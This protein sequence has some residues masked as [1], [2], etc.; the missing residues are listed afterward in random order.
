MAKKTIINSILA[1]DIPY[2]FAAVYFTVG[3]VPLKKDGQP[4]IDANG[5][6]L[7]PPVKE[8]KHCRDRFGTGA[9]VD[10][11]CYDIHFEDNPQRILVPVKKC[12]Q[13]GIVVVE[14]EQENNT[15]ELP[16][17]D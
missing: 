7:F 14:E 15:P 17:A 1:S 2:D 5:E 6:P 13:I 10:Q 8:I 3:G 9:Y 12:S 4:C 16:E 11:P